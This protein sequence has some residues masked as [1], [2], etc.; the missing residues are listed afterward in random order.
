MSDSVT[1]TRYFLGIPFPEDVRKELS[2]FTP[3]RSAGIRPTAAKKLHLTLHFLG[4]LDRQHLATVVEEMQRFQA[5]AF[6][7]TIV[8]AGQFPERGRARVLWAGVESSAALTE[9]HRRTAEMLAKAMGFSAEK[10]CYRPHI[11]LARCQSSVRQRELERF[12][13]ETKSLQ[14]ANIVVDSI[15]LFRS[16]PQQL[17]AGYAHEYE[18]V[19][20]VRLR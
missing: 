9:L 8:G 20:E 17:S 18:R 6:S 2:R 16:Q 11:T 1:D 7:L 19:A 4:P 10:R 3:G 5:A 15:V 14:I 13:Q 12:Q